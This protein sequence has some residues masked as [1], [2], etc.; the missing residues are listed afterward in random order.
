MAAPCTS[1]IGQATHATKHR[2]QQQFA[3]LPS[4]RRATPLAVDQPQPRP[5]A[6]SKRQSQNTT[7]ARAIYCYQR[8]SS[9]RAMEGSLK[10]T[11][12]FPGKKP[13]TLDG[14]ADSDEPR[15]RRRA[16]RADRDA[17]LVT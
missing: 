17:A 9:V 6:S 13:V 8:L 2:H 16:A 11:V 14:L 10:L 15:R 4:C 5:S 7:S 3:E 1:Q 12:E